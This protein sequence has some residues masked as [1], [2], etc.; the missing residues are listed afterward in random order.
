MSID[1]K[2]KLL[3]LY[4]LQQAAESLQEAQYLFSGEKSLRSVVNRIYYGMFY[5]VMA[6]LIYE[7]YTSSKHS[8]VL[9]YFNKHFVKDGLFPNAMGRSL[10]KAFELRQRGDYREYFELKKDQV[11]PL[12][13]EAAQFVDAVRKYLELNNFETRFS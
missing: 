11:E 10:N 7:P 4:R 2:K 12:L 1:E 3:A 5:S 6:L 13:D 8:G 9:G